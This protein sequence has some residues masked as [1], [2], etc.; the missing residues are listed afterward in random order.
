MSP[1]NHK[2]YNKYFILISPDAAHIQMLSSNAAPPKTMS[3]QAPQHI[4][5]FNTVSTQPPQLPQNEI[6]TQPP[7]YVTPSSNNNKCNCPPRN[8]D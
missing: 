8:K 7:P 6:S 4:K 3:F 1:K 5:R 2:I